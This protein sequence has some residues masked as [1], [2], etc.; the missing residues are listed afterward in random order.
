MSNLKEP[1]ENSDLD[2]QYEDF[3]VKKNSTSLLSSSFFTEYLLFTAFIVY[4]SFAFAKKLSP[5]FESNAW[6]NAFI[7]LLT[8]AAIVYA[9]VSVLKIKK[10]EKIFR[11]LTKPAGYG[12]DRLNH[13]SGLITEDISLFFSL[14]D[15]IS[16]DRAK[17]LSSKLISYIY[18]MRAPLK[19]L[20][21]LILALGLLGTFWG[22][23]QAFVSTP[24]VMQGSNNEALS[25][26]FPVM[27]LAFGSVLFGIVGRIIVGFY[28]WRLGA[29]AE[30]LSYFIE[31]QFQQRIEK[32]VVSGAAGEADAP[33][34]LY[35]D[36]NENFSSD[37]LAYRKL[38][39][40]SDKVSS[41][42][43]NF[44]VPENTN[45]NLVGDFST[46]IDKHFEKQNNSFKEMVSVLNENIVEST[47]QFALVSE[48]ADKILPTLGQKFDDIEKNMKK[49]DQGLSKQFTDQV[50]KLGQ[51]I[52]TKDNALVSQIADKVKVASSQPQSSELIEKLDKIETMQKNGFSKEI[53]S[54]VKEAK[55]ITEQNDLLKK[56]IKSLQNSHLD[57]SEKLKSF[58]SEELKKIKIDRTKPL[59]FMPVETPLKD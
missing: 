51:K 50:N 39:E 11:T 15:N 48:K 54:I 17:R 12:E 36:K 10:A 59:M 7:V 53:S 9:F 42:K 8:V 55:N 29:L 18:N 44:L 16:P 43:N 35:D 46:D 49:R 13:K 34:T 57:Q 21:S 33:L 19:Y 14:R 25:S 37:A 3:S 47:K 28:E 52:E 30:K 26:L 1:H 27:S 45:Q 38:I 58:L 31:E 40:L 41:L 6:L 23:L 24:N 4:L 56:D 5:I 20:G 2:T 32:V 22:I